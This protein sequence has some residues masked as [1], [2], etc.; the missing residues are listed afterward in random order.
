MKNPKQTAITFY[1]RFTKKTL[2]IISS[3]IPYLHITMPPLL[4]T[5]YRLTQTLPLKFHLKLKD[6]SMQP[7]KNKPLKSKPC[8]NGC[9]L[10]PRSPL[11]THMILTVIATQIATAVPITILITIMSPPLILTEGLQND[12]HLILMIITIILIMLITMTTR[13]LVHHKVSNYLLTLSHL[14]RTPKICY[15]VTRKGTLPT[16]HFPSP[17]LMLLH[18]A[19]SCTFFPH[20]MNKIILRRLK[21]APYPLHINLCGSPRPMNPLITKNLVMIQS[22]SLIKLLI[23]LPKKQNKRG[24]GGR[25]ISKRKAGTGYLISRASLLI[26]LA[27]FGKQLHT[28]NSWNSHCYPKTLSKASPKPI[29][30][31]HLK[32]TSMTTHA[33]WSFFNI[34][35]RFRV[36]MISPFKDKPA[37]SRTIFIFPLGTN[38]TWPGSFTWTWFLLYI[39]I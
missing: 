37:S 39:H 34:H 21:T 2:I 16:S 30:T 32:Q 4:P 13:N 28:T 1:L 7:L 12:Q 14:S 31:T 36:T 15:E 9:K 3:K 19:R 38:G 27:Q 26:F 10:P 8:F 18:H 20:L 22:L 35:K 29:I 11:T 24:Y 25:Q 23:R 17:T 5:P 6:I 33:Q